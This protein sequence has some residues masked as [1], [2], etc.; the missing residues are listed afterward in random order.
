[1]NFNQLVYQFQTDVPAPSEAKNTEDKWIA[2]SIEAGN[3][4]EDRVYYHLN[5]FGC[6][7]GATSDQKQHS[8]ARQTF[9]EGGAKGRYFV[10]Y[11]QG[12]PYEYNAAAIHELGIAIDKAAQQ[13]ARNFY[14]EIK[15]DLEGKSF[16]IELTRGGDE[17]GDIL[18]KMVDGVFEGKKIMLELKYQ[19]SSAKV[20]WFGL[21]ADTL[22]GPGVFQSWL[23]SHKAEW[24]SYKEAP[25]RWQ[26]KMRQEAVKQF[27]LSSD[28]AGQNESTLL[29][30]LLQKGAALE[31]ENIAKKYVGYGNTNVS[32]MTASTFLNLKSLEAVNAELKA[33]DKSAIFKIINKASGDELGTFGLTKYQKPKETGAGPYGASFNFALYLSQKLFG[34]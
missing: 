20:R 3:Y 4:F 11:S 32:G 6:G 18:V 8:R 2:L 29:A 16:T 9:A 27:L 25:Q 26:N 24:W 14:N 13:T 28:G 33:L 22:F 21:N 10:V 19:L 31:N 34:M 1:M 7:K 30:Y 17:A 12:K 15:K 23:D 5:V